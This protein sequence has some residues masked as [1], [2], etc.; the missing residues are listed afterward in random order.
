[1]IKKERIDITVDEKILSENP[2]RVERLNRTAQFLPV[3]RIPVLIKD[4]QFVALRARGVLFKE[5]VA[6]A[7]DNMRQ[8]IL[9]Y[10]WA[11]ENMFDDAPI[12]TKQLSVT[13]DF[14]ALRGI[15]FPME[16]KWM[17]DQPAKTVHMLH[18]PEQIDTLSVPDPNTG[19]CAKKIQWYKDMLL[20]QEDFDVRLNGTPLELQVVIEQAGG[21]IPS[22]FA[23]AGENLFIWML[24]EPE[25]AHKL[26]QIVTMSFCQVA[27]YFDDLANRSHDH[28]QG[29]GADTAEM[30]SP[31]LF[32]EFVVP[33]YQSVWTRFKGNRLFHMCGKI[34]HLLDILRNDLKISLLDNF[35][36]PTAVGALDDKLA[37]Y[38]RLTGGPSPMLIHDGPVS[39][40]T[41]ECIRYLKI[42]GPKGGFTL[43]AGGGIAPGTPAQHCEAMLKAS[44]RIGFPAK[45]LDKF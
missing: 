27:E 19:L 28:S 40:I 36:F 10:K 21:P 6:S 38:A 32:R 39:S 14:G 41:E 13:Q 4:T 29:M 37:G 3:D 30:L 31:A 43:T 24:T 12:E 42:L 26:M 9:N 25:R 23:L 22:A 34:D 8:Q 17:D 15:E 45:T 7:R 18:E 2:Q 33:Y 20:C 44:R 16:I 35:G 5:Y 11:E 1:M